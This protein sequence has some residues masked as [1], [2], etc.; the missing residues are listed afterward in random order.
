MKIHVLAFTPVVSQCPSY[1][2]TVC[3]SYSFLRLFFAKSLITELDIVKHAKATTNTPRIDGGDEVPVDVVDGEVGGRLLAP[4]APAPL[5]FLAGH[6][7]DGPAGALPLGLRDG[8]LRQDV[9]RRR[10]V[11]RLPLGPPR[12]LGLFALRRL[13]TREL[14]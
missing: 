6:E 5:P 3:L 11:P 9:R 12:R 2:T 7:V 1:H 13:Q 10:Q 4:P 8:R 14:K